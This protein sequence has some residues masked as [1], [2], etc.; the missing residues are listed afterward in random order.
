MRSIVPL[1]LHVDRVLV[2]DADALPLRR[3]VHDRAGRAVVRILPRGGDV[4]E[5]VALRREPLDDVREEAVCK[6]SAVLQKYARCCFHHA[7]LSTSCSARFDPSGSMGNATL[8]I[9][10]PFSNVDG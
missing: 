1:E 10:G 5:R 8:M 7:P 2:H 3:L 9:R 4:E 6:P